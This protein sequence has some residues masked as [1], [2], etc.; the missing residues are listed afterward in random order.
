M[1]C[2]LNIRHPD[3]RV[4]IMPPPQPSPGV[5]GEGV[6]NFATLARM[7][8]RRDRIL[9][10]GS[11]FVAACV[12]LAGLGWGLPSRAGDGYLFGDRP[13][14]TGLRMLA[15]DSALPPAQW[16]DPARGA[17]VDTNPLNRPA[18]RLVL[19]NGDLSSRAE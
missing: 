9:L 10:G 12:F 4:S 15:L 17:D 7:T 16:A 1:C 8:A 19:L 6:E 3:F 5:P 14:V 2:D 18:D 11:L 13:A